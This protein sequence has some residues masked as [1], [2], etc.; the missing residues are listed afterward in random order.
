MGERRALVIGASG[1]DGSYLCEQLG[2]RGV[3]I[4]ALGR[5]GLT[6]RGRHFDEVMLS[7]RRAMRELIGDAGFAEIYY[8]AAYHHSAEDVN[9][10]EGDLV[11]CSFDVHVDGLINVLDGMVAARSPAGLFYAASSHVF[12]IVTGESPQTED[13]PMRPVCAYGTSKAAGVQLCGLY[14]RDY[15]VRACAGFLY[16]HESP[17]R[18]P[19]FLSRKVVRAVAEI[20]RGE[21]QELV[22]GDLDA[23]VDWGYCPEYTMAMQQI[24]NVTDPADYIIASGRT[25]TVRDFIAA[26]FSATGLDW[27]EYTRQDTGMV[28]KHDRGLLVGDPSR[29]TRATGWSARTTAE[30]LARIMLDAERKGYRA[31]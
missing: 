28:K 27:R 19:R 12:G 13:T 4:A 24:L 18:T 21:R 5:K 25:A 23:S 15:G 10:A 16:N 26:A 30:E 8:L 9:Y 29:L 1:Q 20:E 17:R 22:V 31:L 6:W 2:E 11:R 3:E 7:D 14:R